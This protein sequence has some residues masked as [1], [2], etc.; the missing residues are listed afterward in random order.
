MKGN[1]PTQECQWLDWWKSIEMD[2]LQKHHRQGKK[3]FVLH[4]GPPYA[5]GPIHLGHALN[6]IL[7]DFVAR[8]HFSQGYNVDFIPGWDCHG[9]PIEHQIEADLIKNGKKRQDI[10]APEF[11][12][13]CRNFAQHW[14]NV[15]KESFKRLGVQASWD[16]SYQTMD[17]PFE[18][19]ILH[20]FFRLFKKGYV[21]QG[22]RPVLW[23][24]SE[25]T[26]LAEAE[27]E[28]K[29]KISHALY[30]GFSIVSSS[31]DLQGAQA[32]IW[33]TTPWSLPANRAVCYGQDIAYGLYEVEK[34]EPESHAKIGARYVLS[35][36]LWASFSKQIGIEG[37]LLSTVSVD[38]LKESRAQHP[39][40]AAGFDFD[41]PFIPSEFVNTQTG[42]GLVHT[43]P[44]HGL[45]DFIV[46][47]R[48][49]LEVASPIDARGYFLPEIPLV[50]N[51]DMYKAQSVIQEALVQGES[52]IGMHAYTHS[53]PHSWRSKKPLFY[54]ATPQ[55]FIALDA[56]HNVRDKALSALKHVQWFP[57]SGEKRMEATLRT[58]PD[59][60]ISRQRLWGVPIALFTHKKTGEP[61][62]DE[63]IFAR[64]EARVAQEGCDFWFSDQGY[65]VLEGLYP[66]EDWTKHDD[67]IDVWFESGVTHEVV[68]RDRAPSLWPA[69]LYLEGSD[70]H[71]AWFQSSLTLAVALEDR[72]PYHGVITHG[73]T[74]DEKDMKMSKSLGNVIDPEKIVKDK[75]ADIL[76]LWVAYEDYHKDVRLGPS[77]LARVEEMYR[78]FRNT[79]RFCLMN[80]KGFSLKDS[81]EPENWSFREQWIFDQI[82]AQD[83]AFVKDMETYDFRNALHRLHL[84]CSQDL[85]SFYFDSHKDTFYCEPRESLKRRSAQTALFHLFW[86]L[87]HWLSPFLCFTTQEAWACFAKD[88][89]GFDP[90]AKLDLENPF[91]KDLVARDLW[92]PTSY[93]AVHLNTMPQWPDF[94]ENKKAACEMDRI[95]TI[96]EAITSA[97]EKARQ[98]K[99][100]ANSLEA[101]PIVFLE[102][103]WH[104]CAHLEELTALSMVSPIRIEKVDTLPADVHHLGTGVGVSI[105]LAT[106][107][108][109][110]RCWRILDE[111]QGI[112]ALCCRCDSLK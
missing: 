110:E 33:T 85:S 87:V 65:D 48:H 99:Q 60:C 91:L 66:R 43:A 29:D 17:F 18:S 11:R 21:Y 54:R 64:I 14:I 63:T 56:P 107:K 22:L 86:A 83:K 81:V 93:W 95:R 105:Q 96:R 39:L 50:A 112:P 24:P 57:S 55:W 46:G 44:G 53:Y 52:L 75:G 10:S 92:R 34:T 7:K 88:N 15:Q 80:L 20:H 70:Q 45:E 76:R 27:V 41:V 12:T 68:L 79:L 69:N 3:N 31:A 42:T 35:Q 111:V 78:R 97:L 2:K 58:R 101:A 100:I 8:L 37:K 28:Y 89:G 67:I 98:T 32:V 71:R 82:L 25:Q 77:I 62:C 72:P 38:T 108:K 104:N 73:F 9:L 102:P 30:V 6:K 90:L 103:Q 40:A 94:W 19:R 36:E 49:H 106:G 74:L 59:W 109:C 84:F 5:N 26:A 13:Q 61:L 1:L 16:N 23:S 47:Q 4:D 51:M